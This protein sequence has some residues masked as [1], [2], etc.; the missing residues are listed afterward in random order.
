ML[1]EF[2]VSGQHDPNVLACSRA[3][4]TRLTIQRGMLGPGGE[5]VGRPGPAR[6]CKRA[7]CAVPKLGSCRVGSGRAARLSIYS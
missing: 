4:T 6:L 1:I 2:R 3:G 7:C 5:H